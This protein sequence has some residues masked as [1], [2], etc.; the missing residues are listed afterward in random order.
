MA[1]SNSASVVEPH[2]KMYF[3]ADLGDYLLF[4][5]LSLSSTTFVIVACVGV[6]LL[7]FAFEM[8]RKYQRLLKQRFD[9]QTRRN[10]QQRQTEAKPE[11]SQASQKPKVDERTPLKSKVKSCHDKES[12][13][14]SQL[15]PSFQRLIISLLH[16]C[17]VI[18]SSILMLAAMSFHVWI[19]VAIIAGFTFGYYVTARDAKIQS[20]VK[21]KRSN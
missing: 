12:K 9:S 8:T 11:S 10:R 5:D 18:L 14:G 20:L 21:D 13:S 7:A 6:F 17:Q 2:S 1:N 3:H 16:V 19:F 15:H 4:G